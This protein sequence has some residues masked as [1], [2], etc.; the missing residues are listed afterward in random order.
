ME[1]AKGEVR[2]WLCLRGPKL[3]RL[4]PRWSVLVVWVH[5]N[6]LNILARLVMG[7]VLAW[8]DGEDAGV[9]RR[10]DTMLV[11]PCIESVCETLKVAVKDN[12]ALEE[13]MLE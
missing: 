7:I 8:K 12:I 11:R 9:A 3:A 2:G 5:A 10:W 13:V 1:C 4:I 6:D